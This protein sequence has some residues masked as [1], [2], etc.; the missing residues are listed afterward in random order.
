MYI[1]V[2]EA[3]AETSSA[4]RLKVGA[5]AVKNNMVIGTGYNGLSSGYTGSCEEKIYEHEEH[6]FRSSDYPFGDNNGRYRLETRKEVNHA[7]LNLILNLAKST[8]S[9]KGC[10]VFLTHAC[11]DQCSKL[12]LDSG[13]RAVYYRHQYRSTEGLEYLIANGVQV[14]QI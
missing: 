6:S 1:R 7:E 4:I 10:S 13:V 11:C 14:E 5:V 8:E 2:A 3:V 12:L 9:S